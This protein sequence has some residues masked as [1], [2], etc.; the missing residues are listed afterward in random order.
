MLNLF[1]LNFNTAYDFSKTQGQKLPFRFLGGSGRSAHLAIGGSVIDDLFDVDERGTAI[2]I[3][4]L[5]PLLGS[6]IG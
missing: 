4:P 5:A 2:N 6:I 3:Y 1:C